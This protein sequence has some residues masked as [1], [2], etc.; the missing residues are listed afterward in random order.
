MNAKEI[1]L[2]RGCYPFFMAALLVNPVFAD[3]QYGQY[4]AVTEKPAEK[5]KEEVVHETV[6]ADLGDNLFLVAVALV[7]MAGMFADACLKCPPSILSSSN[8]S[9]ILNTCP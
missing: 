3:G 4:G 2:S 5:P 7:G 1:S 9:H 8:F 6:E